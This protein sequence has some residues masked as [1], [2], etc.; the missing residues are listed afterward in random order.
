MSL[1]RVDV[2]V[3]SA[4]CLSVDRR[5]ALAAIGC[6]S[7]VALVDLAR[8]FDRPHRLHRESRWPVDGLAWSPHSDHVLAATSHATLL[9]WD[10]ARAG[11]RSAFAST[12][13]SASALCHVLSAAPGA[14]T[15]L[16]G[17]AW[18]AGHPNLLAAGSAG[19]STYLWDLRAPEETKRTLSSK[20]TTQ[21]GLGVLAV[22]WSPRNAHLIA[23]L[24]GAGGEGGAS[25][26]IG[27]EGGAT[28]VRVWD[29][30][31]VRGTGEQTHAARSAPAARPASRT[32]RGAL[33]RGMSGRRA[34]AQLQRGAHEQRAP[35]DPGPLCVVSLSPAHGPVAAI[36]WS[37]LRASVLC[38]ASRDGAGTVAAWDVAAAA[39]GADGG[40]LDGG[41]AA[42]AAAAAAPAVDAAGVARARCVGLFETGAPVRA[43]RFAPRGDGVVTLA[44]GA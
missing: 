6:A 35:R 33:F 12:A 4:A 15:P 1:L 29:L 36:A 16:C 14:T 2:N 40:A 27:G 10:A 31:A 32:P 20:G 42:A 22:E 11:S 34:A 19:G 26:P 30:R 18:C 21:L 7:G 23:T 24:Y 28:A 38:T 41:A 44:A 37:A 39:S 3:E 5:G 9:V 17:V 43:L 25:A 8:P 13:P